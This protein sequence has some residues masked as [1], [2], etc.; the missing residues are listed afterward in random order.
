[1]VFAVQVNLIY[2]FE[3]KEE[4]CMVLTLM[5]GG[6]LKYHIHHMGE[7]GLDIDRAIF[8]AAEIT[9][10]LQ[11]MHEASIVYRYVWSADQDQCTPAFIN[12]VL[13]FSAYS[14]A[15]FICRSYCN[16]TNFRCSFIFGIFG[17]Q[18]FY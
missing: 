17:G 10:G 5:D 16:F 2:A 7:A 15:S 14:L 6:D 8:Y 1:M 9:C 13:S 11:H 4:L 18:W 3:T 12:A